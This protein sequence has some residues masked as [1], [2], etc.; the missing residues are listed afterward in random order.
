MFIFVDVETDG[1]I[2]GD[3][4]MVEIGAVAFDKEGKF[5]NTFYGQLRPLSGAKWDEGALFSFGRTR[6]ETLAFEPAQLTI[7]KFNKW[8][9]QFERPMFI[10][11]NAGFDWMFVCWYMWHFVNENPFG[12]SS[13]S[14]T[15]FYKGITKDMFASFKHL[16]KTKHDHNPVNDAM[17]N[18][19]AFLTIINKNNVKGKF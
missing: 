11:D 1:P 12:F 3:Y 7:N 2:P 9:K 18:A 13:T 16:R 17:G 19:E 14:L 15:S 6:A 10:S 5:D 4:S 8:V